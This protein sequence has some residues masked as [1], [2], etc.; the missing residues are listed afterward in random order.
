MTSEQL[1]TAVKRVEEKVKEAD[2]AIEVE[3]DK[4]QKQ[5]K[6]KHRR[7]MDKIHQKLKEDYLPRLEKYEERLATF[8]D[9]NSY[10]KTDH[11]ATFMRM[12]E[13]HMKNGQLKPGY[14]VQMQQ[15]INLL[16]VTPFTKVRH[17]HAVSSLTLRS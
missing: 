4:E 13:D 5:I 12:K 14:N 7:E 15:K 11:D 1:K 9:R 2:K 16:S 3:E 10:S 6:K 17:I 8:G